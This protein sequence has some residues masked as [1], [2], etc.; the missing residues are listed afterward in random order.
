[1]NIKEERMKWKH[2]SANVDKF[3]DTMVEV[4]KTQGEAV[5][6]AYMA[7]DMPYRQYLQWVH[8]AQIANV[9]PALVRNSMVNLMAVM[10]I[11]ASTRMGGGKDGQRISNLEWCDDCLVDIREEVME[12]LQQMAAKKIFNGG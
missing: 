9:D 4:L 5:P 12:D 7:I 8:S 10:L 11:E 6:V 1:M 2:D 3:V